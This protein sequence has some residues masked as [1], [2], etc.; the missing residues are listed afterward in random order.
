MA[1]FIVALV[2]FVVF[3]IIWLSQFIQLMLLADSDFPGAYDKILWV[4]AFVCVFLLAPLAFMYWKPAYLS[5]RMEER[6]NR[7]RPMI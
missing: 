4:A 1:S 6:Q 2:V 3:A 5:L 7:K